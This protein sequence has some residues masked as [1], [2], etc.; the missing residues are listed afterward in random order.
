[1]PTHTD[2]HIINPWIPLQPC[3]R[4]LFTSQPFQGNL[5]R[6]SLLICKEM[7]VANHSSTP[8]KAISR[9]VSNLV[10]LPVRKEL[11][12]VSYLGWL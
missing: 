2:I 9:I 11:N 6:T 3:N 4:T 5:Q 12:S 1:M 7:G 8:F 10:S